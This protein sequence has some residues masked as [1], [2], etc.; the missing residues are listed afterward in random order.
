MLVHPVCVSSENPCG[1]FNYIFVGSVC[2][3]QKKRVSGIQRTKYKGNRVENM[4]VDCSSG[5]HIKMSEIKS[6][7]GST[8][9]IKETSRG[10]YIIPQFLI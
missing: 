4:F 8:F 10:G 9:I 6:R 5:V 3:Q 1:H 7:V 2:F